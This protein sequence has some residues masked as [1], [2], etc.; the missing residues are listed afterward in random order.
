[1][2]TEFMFGLDMKSRVPRSESGA[3]SRLDRSQ[4]SANTDAGEPRV[5]AVGM[6][7]RLTR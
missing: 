2:Q 1:V 5:I 6:L 4:G 3:V 7:F